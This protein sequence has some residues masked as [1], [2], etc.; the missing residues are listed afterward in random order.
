MPSEDELDGGGEVVA[1]AV[2]IDDELPQQP[3]SSVEL[4]R[5]VRI[6]G[7]DESEEV[8]VGSL[9]SAVQIVAARS[10]RL[11]N[12][13]SPIASVSIG[14]ALCHELSIDWDASLG[15][16]LAGK[17]NLY[18]VWVQIQSLET[19]ILFSTLRHFAKIIELQANHCHPP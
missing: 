4:V 14:V 11:N 13:D 19:K 8:H 1:L 17:Q 18:T 16:A 3:V 7:L 12:Y 10:R 6:H 9:G 5:A 2:S 15:G